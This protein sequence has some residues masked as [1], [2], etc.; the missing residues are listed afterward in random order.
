TLTDGLSGSSTVF[1]TARISASRF[2]SLSPFH[3]G[4]T[5]LPNSFPVGIIYLCH[6]F[7]GM[8]Q[9]P[10]MFAPPAMPIHAPEWGV[11]DAYQGRFYFR[12]P[13]VFYRVL[14]RHKAKPLHIARSVT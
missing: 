1:N 11:W 2:I 9:I 10:G 7:D 12:V 6:G 8:C 5:L 13:C 14:T 4:H 3:C